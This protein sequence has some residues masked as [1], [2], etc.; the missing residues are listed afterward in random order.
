MLKMLNNNNKKKKKVFSPFQDSIKTSI[1]ME[2]P[3]LK[4]YK[5]HFELML[6]GA[7]ATKPPIPL[8]GGGG[9][10]GGGMAETGKIQM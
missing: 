2:L 4:L 9:G 3:H 10:G 1:K 6:R 8:Y 5:F 7:F